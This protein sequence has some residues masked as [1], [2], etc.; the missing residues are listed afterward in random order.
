MQGAVQQVQ[1]EEEG[2]VADTSKYAGSNA[3]AGQPSGTVG[4]RPTK[5][6]TSKATEGFTAAK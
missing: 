5:I 6:Q 2:A 3:E 1:K 4:S